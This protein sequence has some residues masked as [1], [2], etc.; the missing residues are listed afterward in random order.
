MSPSK[1]NNLHHLFHRDDALLDELLGELGDPAGAAP[2][3][4]AADILATARSPAG[5]SEPT[6]WRVAAAVL[7]SASLSA[8]GGMSAWLGAEAPPPTASTAL[9]LPAASAPAPRTSAPE[10]STPRPPQLQ[11]DPN[12]TEHV[13]EAHPEQGEPMAPSQ[14]VASAR[15]TDPARADAPATTLSL[16]GGLQTNP[17]GSPLGMVR[18]TLAHRLQPDSSSPLLGATAA[19]TTASDPA[20]PKLDAFVPE[21]AVRVGWSWR[22]PRLRLDTGWGLGLRG[23]RAHHRAL[24]PTTGPFLAA[25]AT[26]PSGLVLTSEAGVEVDLDETHGTPSPPRLGLMVGVALPVA[27]GRG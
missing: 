11:A 9:V 23:K 21:A 16:G 13:A 4:S 5:R 27:T 25:S 18:A 2:E 6:T 7:L 12:D 1:S 15:A 17:E 10:P 14:V 3:R 22:G 24:Q 20:A 26:L 8:W 19:L